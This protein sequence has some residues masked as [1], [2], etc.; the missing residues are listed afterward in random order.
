MRQ[1]PVA[2]ATSGVSEA[3]RTAGGPARSRVWAATYLTCV[4]IFR[5]LYLVFYGEPRMPAEKY[6][7]SHEAPSVMT[8]PLV[9]LAIGAAV[10]GVILEPWLVGDRWRAFW[11][12]SVQI[13]AWNHAVEGMENLPVWAASLPLAATLAGMA[14]IF[15]CYVLAPG[16][17]A[18][19]AV[20]FRPVYLFLLNKWYFDEL[21][22]FLFVCPFFWLARQ[23]WQVGDGRIINGLGP[24]GVSARVVDLTRNVVRPDRL[25]L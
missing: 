9:A 23:L 3:R 24:D 13:A 12:D 18:W 2:S 16:I 4:Y 14:T 8:G 10:L 1:R 6:A 22:H 7:H 17:P 25:R 21:Y 19:L 15:V 11:R 20:T 5:E